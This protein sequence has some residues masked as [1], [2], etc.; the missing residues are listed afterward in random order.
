MGHI[1]IP[2][3]RKYRT[4]NQKV[5]IATVTYLKELAFEQPRHMRDAQESSRLATAIACEPAH[6]TIIYLF[7]L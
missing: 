2:L 3:S 4:E 7:L 1:Y 5:N 6:Y